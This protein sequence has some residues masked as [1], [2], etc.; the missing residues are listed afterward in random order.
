MSNNTENLSSAIQAYNDELTLYTL[1]PNKSNGTKVRNAL[2]NMN[3]LTKEV[4][5]DV[6]VAQKAIP[7]KTRVQKVIVE[8]PEP[9]PEVV[10]APVG[11]VKK[12]RAKKI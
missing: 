10:E 7:K 3:K 8:E 4:R 6:L 12:T 11:K 2:M 9:E 1:K 5:K